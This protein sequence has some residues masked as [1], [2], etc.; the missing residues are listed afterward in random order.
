[1][2]SYLKAL[3]N[4]GIDVLR[5]DSL[6]FGEEYTLPLQLFVLGFQL[7]DYLLVSAFR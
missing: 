3:N 6:Q 5:C 4:V 7:Y 1:M 2:P